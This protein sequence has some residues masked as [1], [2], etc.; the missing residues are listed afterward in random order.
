MKTIEITYKVNGYCSKYLKV[1]DDY[2]APSTDPEV[3]WDDL[4]R[5]CGGQIE[6]DLFEL[7]FAS[8]QG[9]PI[10]NSNIDHIFFDQFMTVWIP[11]DEG[12]EERII[13]RQVPFDECWPY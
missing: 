4:K 13:L 8:L 1:P 12:N 3:V 6:D 9:F 5:R 11:D 2:Q 10:S 7:D